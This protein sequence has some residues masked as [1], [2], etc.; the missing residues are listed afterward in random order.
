LTTLPQNIAAWTPSANGPHAW[1]PGESYPPFV[2]INDHGDHVSI[3][4]RDDPKNE[5]MGNTVAVRMARED[6]A[7]LTRQLVAWFARCPAPVAPVSA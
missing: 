7:E 4:V 3:L 5:R 1:R 6:A 2:S